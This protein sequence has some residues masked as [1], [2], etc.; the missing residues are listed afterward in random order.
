GGIGEVR[1]LELELVGVNDRD[2]TVSEARAAVPAIVLRANDVSPFRLELRPAG[3]EVRY[4]L[5]Y[6]YQAKDSGRFSAL[7]PAAVQLLAQQNQ[8]FMARNACGAHRH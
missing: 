4:D 3:T 6:Q 8:R 1:F 5:Y 2:R 7:D